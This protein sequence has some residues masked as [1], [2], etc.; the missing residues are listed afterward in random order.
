[1]ASRPD[2]ARH[3]FFN[4]PYIYRLSGNINVE[5][6]EQARVKIV[7]RHETLR[8]VFDVVCGQPMQ[9]VYEVTNIHL[10]C[11]DLRNTEPDIIA[12]RAAAVILEERK[13]PFQLATGPLFRVALVR[14][15]ETESLLLITMHHIVSDHRSMQILSQELALIY[16]HIICWETVRFHETGA[17]IC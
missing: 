14:L 16:K 17:S 9:V 11:H 15:T 2:D 10:A 1:M 6:L 12:D 3:T 7:R 8:T 5:A 13:Y 4:I